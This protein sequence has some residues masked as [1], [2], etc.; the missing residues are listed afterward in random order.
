MAKA[1]TV[2]LERYQNL[3]AYLEVRYCMI[4]DTE[5]IDTLRYSNAFVECKTVT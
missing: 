1:R 3:L 2:K 4:I 5:K